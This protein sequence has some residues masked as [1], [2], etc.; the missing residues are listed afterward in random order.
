MRTVEMEK[1]AFRG[2][3]CQIISFLSTKMMIIGSAAI[4]G[5]GFASG[6]RKAKL[7]A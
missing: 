2:T 4:I 6:R 1:E 5:M 7:L 3:P